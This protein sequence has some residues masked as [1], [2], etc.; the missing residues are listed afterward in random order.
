MIMEKIL[1]KIEKNKFIDTGKSI[2][3]DVIF[4]DKKYI[5]I[6]EKDL[7][8]GDNNYVLVKADDV[9][10]ISEKASLIEAKEISLE[11]IFPNILEFSI[12][13]VLKKCCD[14]KIVVN[15]EYENSYYER[16]GIIEKIGNKRLG[17]KEIDKINGVFNLKNEI[18]I[19]E[20]SFMFI[21]NYSIF[22]D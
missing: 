5:L 18:L 6:Y 14:E 4:Q 19:D 12:H 15:F 17:L 1:E 10:E 8:Y 21:K 11:K 3:G 2:Q 20:I 7:F 16:Y 9:W 13:D 22:E